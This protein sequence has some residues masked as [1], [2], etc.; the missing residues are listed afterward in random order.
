MNQ[1]CFAV[2]HLHSMSIA[3]RD[4]KPENLLLSTNDDSAIIK[5]TDFGFAK[6]VS[7]GLVTPWYIIFSYYSFSVA[8]TLQ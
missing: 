1:I 6:E 7:S 2:K 5:L 8:R 3:H 4:L